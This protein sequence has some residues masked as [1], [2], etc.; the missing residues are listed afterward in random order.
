MVYAEYRSSLQKWHRYPDANVDI[1][2]ISAYILYYASLK[3]DKRRDECLFAVP[4]HLDH[5]L[6]GSNVRQ[7]TSY[8]LDGFVHGLSSDLRINLTNIETPQSSVFIALPANRENQLWTAHLRIYEALPVVLYPAAISASDASQKV[9][10]PAFSDFQSSHQQ[11][12]SSVER[13]ILNK[14]HLVRYHEGDSRTA[15]HSQ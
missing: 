3:Q 10:T 14:R 4:G 2:L 12:P 8:I 7:L 15:I 11:V 13:D 6:I 9:N 1:Y 5:A